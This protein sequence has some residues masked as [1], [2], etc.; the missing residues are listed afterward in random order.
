MDLGEGIRKALAKV[1]GASVVDEAAVEELVKELQ[2]VLISN[3]VNVQLVLDLTGKIKQQAINEKPPAGIA[4]REHVV[5]IVYDQLVKMVG[6]SYTPSMAGHRIMMCGLF[7]SGKTTTC[8]KIARFYQSR[9]MR[10]GLIAA[11]VHRPAAYEQL[12]QLAHLVG[13]S[14]YGR[15]GATAVQVA[16]EGVA[17]LSD[18]QV[19]VLDTAGRSAF[20]SELAVELQEMNSLFSPDQVFLVVSADIGQVAGRQAHQFAQTVPLTGVI[21]TKMDGSGKGGGALSA[22]AEGGGQIAFIGTGEKPEALAVFDSKSFVAGLCGFA[23]LPALLEKLKETSQEE[24]LVKAM[25]SGK[26][27]YEAFMAQMKALR[28]MGPLKGVLQMMGAY[29][30]PQEIVGKSEERMKMFEAAVNSMTPYE[31]KHPETMRNANRQLRVAKGA[32]LKP[33]VVRELVTNFEKT[34]KMM[35]GITSNRGMMRKLGKMLPKGMGG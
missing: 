14:F 27:D 12:E 11:D 10:V 29:D 35:K 32:G 4:L 6:E 17:N 24:A 16:T 25:E 2:R 28:K 20:D 5:K 22:V 31:R 7:G 30:L 3:D 26:L 1:T 23:D 9:G 34:S 15:K 21:I 8:A 33:E 13:C 19:L 18:C